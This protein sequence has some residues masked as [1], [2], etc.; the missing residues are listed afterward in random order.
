M[1]EALEVPGVSNSW[2]LP[3]RNRIEMQYTG[4]RTPIGMKV[5]GPD[6][7]VIQEVGQQVEGVLRGIA[8]TRSAFA[9]R[10]GAGYFLDVD[11]KREELARYGLTVDDVEPIISN[12]V[13]GDEISTVMKWP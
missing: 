3:I 7:K 2:T 1:N 13:G 11:V 8:G 5:S 12:A 6:P 10:T 4:I 9:E